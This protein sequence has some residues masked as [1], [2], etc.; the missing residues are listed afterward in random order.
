MSKLEE[1]A[2]CKET[3]HFYM[4]DGLCFIQDFSS[5]KLLPGVTL[6]FL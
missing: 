1:L 6:D 2:S 5:V 4:N 3:L